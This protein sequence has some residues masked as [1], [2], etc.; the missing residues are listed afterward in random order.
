MTVRC[1]V[2]ASPAL[3]L[4]VG[5]EADGFTFAVSGDR[6]LVRPVERLTP[7]QRAL[8]QRER[9]AILVLLRICDTG[10]Q[11]RREAFA[12]QLQAN[13]T[14]LVPALVFRPDVPYVAGR[15]FSC[16]DETGRPSFGRCARCALAWRL[17]LGVAIPAEF[18]AAYDDAKRVA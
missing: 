5:L 18:A 10:V 16:G 1:D 7:E 11:A 3:P 4:L 14:A 8:L 2:F 17:A 13:S 15:C 9:A 6:L 12:A